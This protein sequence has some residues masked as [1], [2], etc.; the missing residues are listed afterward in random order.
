[1]QSFLDGYAQGLTPNP[2]LICNRQIKW[3]FYS[4]TPWRWCRL[5]R[6]RP[7]CRK[8]VVENGREELLRAMDP[9]KDQSYVYTC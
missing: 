1:V 7:F 5:S 2:C 6:I 8:Q 9:A 3:A 4:S